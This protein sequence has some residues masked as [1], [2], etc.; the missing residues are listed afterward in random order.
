MTCL[1]VLP[2]EIAL[3]RV[4]YA[5]MAMPIKCLAT[6]GPAEQMPFGRIQKPPLMH[7]DRHAAFIPPSASAFATSNSSAP[8]KATQD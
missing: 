3:K 7:N 4:H 1:Q 8:R 5:M 6:Q 2:A